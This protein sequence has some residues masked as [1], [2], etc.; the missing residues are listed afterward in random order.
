MRVCF[1]ISSV[2]HYLTSFTLLIIPNIR[3]NVK[4]YFK[5]F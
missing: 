4:R 3:Y 1:F 5:L 2:T